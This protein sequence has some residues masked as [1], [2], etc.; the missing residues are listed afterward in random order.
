MDQMDGEVLVVDNASRDAT[1]TVLAEEFPTIRVIRNEVNVHYT[2]AVNQG[3]RATTGKYVFL[4]NDDTEL[5]PDSLQTLTA[6]A[7][8]HPRCGAVGPASF[9]P[10]HSEP[11]PSAQRFPTPLREL[12]AISGVAWMLRHWAASIQKLY[13]MPMRSQRVDWV[14]GGFIFLRRK[15]IEALGYHD[16]NYLI[17]RDDPDIGMRLR[18][19]GWEVWYCAEARLMHHH[20]M[21]TVKTANRLRFDLIAVRSRR[22][23]Y[24]KFHGL[25]GAVA[26]ECTDGMITLLRALKSL[27]L[28]RVGTAREH[29]AHLLTLFEAFQMPD[30]ERRA[31]AGYRAAAHNGIVALAGSGH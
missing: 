18:A 7:E 19:A 28:L 9:L 6:F 4:L 23:Y 22:H 26:V 2:R 3:M 8:A 21:T 14:G 5:E 20:G 12:M 11:E 15:V 16:E 13:A 29:G 31:I 24:R 17:Y 10:G 1:T 27:L 30:E 25:G